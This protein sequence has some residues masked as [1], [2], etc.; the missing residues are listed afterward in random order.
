MYMQH[1]GH[2]RDQEVVE[3]TGEIYRDRIVENPG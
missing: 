3:N 1:S 2:S